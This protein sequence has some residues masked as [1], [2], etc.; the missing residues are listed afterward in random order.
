[1]EIVY[2]FPGRGGRHLVDS[3]SPVPSLENLQGAHRVVFLAS[4]SCPVST[5]TPGRPHRPW[6]RWLGGMT[7]QMD[8]G[9]SDPELGPACGAPMGLRMAEWSSV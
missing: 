2:K 1:M 8:A 9:I 5:S 3:S 6:R 7:R 4:Y